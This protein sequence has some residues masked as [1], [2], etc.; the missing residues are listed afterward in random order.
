MV[1]AAL[2]SGVAHRRA[3]FELWARTLPRGRRYGVVAGTARAVAAV[4]QF[5]FGAAELDFLAGHRVLSDVGLAW[6][7]DFRF[8]GDIDGYPEGEL[9]FPESPVLTVEASFAEAVVLET[10]LL[11]V[12]NH[13]SAVASAACRMAL[14]ARGRPIIE[15]GSRRTHEE[16]AVAAARA[17]YLAGFASTSNLEAGRRHGVPT[18]GTVAH[19]FIMAHGDELGAFVAQIGAQGTGTTVLV[20]TYDVP[21]GVRRAVEAAGRFGAAGPGAI[22]IDAGDLAAGCREARVLL[23]GLGA[24]QT[25]IV[26]SGDLDEFRIDDLERSPGGRAPIDAYGVGTSLATGSGHPTAGFIYKLVAIAEGPDATTLRPVHKDQAGK[27]THGGRK[28]A[29]RLLDSTGLAVAE[30]LQTHSHASGGP[31]SAAPA[32]GRAR[33]LQVPLVRGGEP[34]PPPTLDEVR[35]RHVRFRAELAPEALGMSPGRPALVA[36]LAPAEPAVGGT[37]R[38]P[39]RPAR[40]PNEE[41]R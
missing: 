2:R 41:A 29:H 39:A 14:A 30:V 11:S 12:L 3:V 9:Y 20:D 23:D 28:T 38:A 22:R 8:S 37:T 19:A 24:E 10:L 32:G 13:D 36:R 5:R 6:L 40:P 35:A 7:A 34:I 15:M 27:A 33:A 25:R 17:A 4:S 18:A 1:D 21:D 31:G 16:S 26:A